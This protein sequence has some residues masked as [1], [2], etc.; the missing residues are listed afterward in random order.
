MTDRQ[1]AVDGL[2]EALRII[3]GEPNATIESYRRSL[4]L[5]REIARAALAAWEQAASAA[6]EE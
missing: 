5:A 2:V 1:A 6:K 3:A 4:E